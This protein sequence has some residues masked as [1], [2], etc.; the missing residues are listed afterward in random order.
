MPAGYSQ[1]SLI[2]KLG[3]APGQRILIVNPPEGYDR[4]LG[5]V[6]AG[7]TRLRRVA[8]SPDVIQLFVTSRAQLEARWDGLAGALAPGGMLWVSWPKRGSGVATDLTEDI[9]RQVGLPRGLVDVKVCAVDQVWSGL[10]FVRRRAP[11]SASGDRAPG[12][13]ARSR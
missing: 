1:R 4:T 3:I 12:R 5:P 10:K 2:A 9:L 6:P 13:P 7:V 8:G 11:A